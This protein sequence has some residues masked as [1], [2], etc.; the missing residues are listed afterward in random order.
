MATRC[1]GDM[2]YFLWFKKISSLIG[3]AW[4][5][6]VSNI[7]LHRDPV[8]FPRSDLLHSLNEIVRELIGKLEYKLHFCVYKHVI[9]SLAKSK[10]LKQKLKS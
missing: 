5:Q 7:N 3:H 9:Y 8:D 2:P 4:L 1:E 10:S 6:P